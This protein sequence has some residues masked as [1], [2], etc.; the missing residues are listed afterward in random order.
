M[1]DTVLLEKNLPADVVPYTGRQW[2][3]HG[4][5]LPAHMRKPVQIDDDLWISPLGDL[6]KPIMAA[7][8]PPGE[9]LPVHRM[10]RAPFAFCRTNPPHGASPESWWDADR[11]I[12]IAVQLSRLIRP[13]TMAYRYACR[14][15]M[16]ADGRVIQPAGIFGQGAQAYTMNVE[17]DALKDED[18]TPLRALIKAF[19]RPR[20]PNRVK[21]A[22]WMTE[23]LAWTRLM[24]IRWPL[25]VTAL[26]ALVHTDDRGRKR[27]RLLGSTDQFC[28]RLSKLQSMLRT[29]LWTEP[30]LLQIYDL[31]SSFA[32]GRGGNVDSLRGEPLRLYSAV[33]HGL[34]T[35]L[36]VAI[37]KP[38]V[39]EI[40]ASDVSIRAT[41]GF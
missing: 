26:E 18:I 22:L 36:R 13:W 16:N 5:Q 4:E 30:D 38:H 33:E 6:R 8:E 17:S 35:I 11:R 23:H 24:N 15:S 14:L 31:R 34:R 40:F 9:N 27:G 19:D 2:L 28:L 1:I 12:Q 20:L 39:A 41:L 29:P 37:L 25:A 32:H 3:S 21:N 7:S 10:Y